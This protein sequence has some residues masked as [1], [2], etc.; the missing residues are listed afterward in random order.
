[1]TVWGVFDGLTMNFV[2]FQIISGE[3]IVIR[4]QPK[5]GPPPEKTITLSSIKAPKLAK[6]ATA[7]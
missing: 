6:R 4:G 2:S 7:G 5:G 3:S 1:M